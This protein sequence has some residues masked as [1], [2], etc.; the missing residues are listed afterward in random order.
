M[1]MIASTKLIVASCLLASAALST[2][3]LGQDSGTQS[4]ARSIILDQLDR[5]EVEIHEIQDDFDLLR[6]RFYW[7]KYELASQWQKQN[8]QSEAKEL[9]NYAQVMTLI[10][11]IKYAVSTKTLKMT[12]QMIS[13]KFVPLEN[14]LVNTGSGVLM[15][16]EMVP[17][18][19][20]R[21]IARASIEA[22]RQSQLDWNWLHKLTEHYLQVQREPIFKKMAKEAY[23]ELLRLRSKERNLHEHYYATMKSGLE[24]MEID[25]GQARSIVD[26]LDFLI[27]TAM[28][29]ASCHSKFPSME[30][31]NTRPLFDN[32]QAVMETLMQTIDQDFMESFTSFEDDPSVY[33][34]SRE[35]QQQVKKYEINALM[36]R[37]IG[38]A[39]TKKGKTRV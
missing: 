16:A 4:K 33:H 24:Q 27:E 23:H 9:I 2:I 22:D 30:Y 35:E 29:C 11:S 25:P 5:I 10:E 34:V 36:E 6:K 18:L 7:D 15:R 28:G 38:G 3:C 14:G 39:A 19:V 17:I 20:A 26:G 12:R 21:A 1:R 31:F 8:R 32:H 37:V 13:G